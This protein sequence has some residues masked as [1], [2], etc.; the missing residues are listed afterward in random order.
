MPDVN[1][2]SHRTE[3][4]IVQSLAK[5]DAT[6]LGVALGSL[7]GLMIFLATNIL[8]LKGGEQIG[9]NLGLLGN[10][11]IGYDVTPIGSIV[12]L[13]YGFIVGF[14]IGWLIASVRNSAVMTYL[15]FLKLKAKMSAVNDYLD[16]P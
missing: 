13:G 11:F 5:I 1:V 10:F 12:G 14:A 4:L 6:A 9:T 3:D 2:K 8:V 16:H 7:F 15:Y